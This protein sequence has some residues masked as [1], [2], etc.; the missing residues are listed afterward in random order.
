MRLRS[1]LA[2]AIVTIALAEISLR[3]LHRFQPQFIFYDDSYNRWRRTPGAQDM[4]IKLNTLGF[5]DEE[6]SAKQPD[7]YRIV[8]LGD[9]FSYGNVPHR[10]NFLTVLENR[11]S[12]A[13]RAEVLNMGIPGTGPLDYLNLFAKEGLPLDPDAVLVTFFVGNDIVEGA[14]RERPGFIARHSY[15]WAT[16]RYLFWVRPFVRTP[17]PMPGRDTNYTDYCDTCPT[18]ELGRF[19]QIETQRAVIF[20]NNQSDTEEKIEKALQPVFALADLCRT[21]GIEFAIVLAPDEVQV[22][23]ELAAL[24]MRRGYEPYRDHWDP[25]FP[26]RILSEKLSSREIPVLDLYPH[27]ARAARHASLY[28]PQNTHWNIRGNRLAGEVIARWL[29]RSAIGS[30]VANGGW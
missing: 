28:I 13:G 3:V 7:V 5:K 26:H 23:T 29:Q 2:I 25:E 15:L 24:V 8:A 6:F 14:S 11:L 12:P 17:P 10:Y 27:F 18:L 16:L 21:R 1:L 19:L 20:F 30:A 4:D 9:S 22:N